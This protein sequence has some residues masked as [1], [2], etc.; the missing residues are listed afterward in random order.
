VQRCRA[1]EEIRTR[2]ELRDAIGREHV[3]DF[4]LRPI[5]SDGKTIAMIAEGRDISG[6]VGD[7]KR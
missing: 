2:A 7:S 3:L 1:G 4:S 5:V 6:L